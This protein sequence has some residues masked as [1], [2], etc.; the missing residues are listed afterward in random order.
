[1]DNSEPRRYLLAVEAGS[2][3][4]GTWPPLQET[5]TELTK[6]VGLLTSADFR[7]QRILEACSGEPRREALL[8]ALALWCRSDQRR[9]DDHLIL[10]WT[11]HGAVVDERLYLVLPTTQ[12]LIADGLSLDDLISVVLGAGSRTGPTLLLLDM[13]FAG[14]GIVDMGARWG[15]MTRARHADR[16]AELGVICAA[17]ARGRA[18]QLV[19]ADAFTEAASISGCPSV[20][21]VFL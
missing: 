8:K 20:S 1:M 2:Y 16:P 15:A 19:F 9:H 10:Y 3:A 21:S 18:R 5:R 4:G 13:C 7:Y 17:G 6:V 12:D 14:Q 11:G